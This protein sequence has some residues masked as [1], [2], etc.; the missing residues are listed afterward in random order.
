[1]LD[2]LA[3]CCPP[4]P[5][6]PVDRRGRRRGPAREPP[7]GSP[8]VAWCLI[9]SRRTAATTPRAGP[10]CACNGS[11]SRVTG[12]LA[13]ALGRTDKARRLLTAAIAMDE[14]MAP[15]PTGLCRGRVACVHAAAG[16]RTT[17]EPLARRAADTPAWDRI[18]PALAAATRECWRGCAPSPT[19]R[20]PPARPRGSARCWFAPRLAVGRPTGRSRSA[21]PSHRRDHVG[22]VGQARRGQRAKAAAWPPATPL[23]PTVSRGGD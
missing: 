9:S 2:E 1:M 11:V 17:A 14:R 19:R 6:R 21:L 3:P 15:S 10:V 20:G 8:T 7:R 12:C 23:T 16:E 5:Q 18:P 22:H 13:A 4:A